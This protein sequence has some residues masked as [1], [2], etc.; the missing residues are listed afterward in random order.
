MEQSRRSRLE[1]AVQPAPVTVSLSPVLVGLR[2]AAGGGDGA[3][4]RKNL[5][6][7]GKWKMARWADE[8]RRRARLGQW[9]GGWLDANGI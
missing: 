9:A 7:S 2:S 1:R 8:K 6:D 4:R 3:W 5:G